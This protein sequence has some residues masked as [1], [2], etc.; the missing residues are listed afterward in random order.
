MNH[1]QTAKQRTMCSIS[2]SLSLETAS[3]L[4][5]P[6]PKNNTNAPLVEANLHMLENTEPQKMKK[7]CDADGIR[8][9]AN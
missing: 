5:Q 6:P 7:R 1:R 9:R 8:T 4:F 2:L 3:S